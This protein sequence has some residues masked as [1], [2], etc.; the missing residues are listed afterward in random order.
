MPTIRIPN[1][2]DPR[3]Y[4]LGPWK[5]LEAG[6][7]RAFLLWHRRAGKDDFC[8][9][10]T[11]RSALLRPATYW[12]MLPQAA[13]ARKAIWEAVNPHTGIRRIDEAFPHAIR[14]TTREQEMMIRFKN[15]ST[16]QVVGSDNFNSLV[17]SPPA[18][19]V[20]SEFALAD[21]SA[22]AYLRP[23]LAENGGWALFVTT[24]R[25]KNHAYKL[26]KHAEDSDDWFCQRLT[27]DDTG[28][29]TPET[30]ASEL[31][32]MI[33]QFGPEMGRSLFDQEYY[34]SFDA[35]NIGAVYG[36]QMA[37]MEKDGRIRA[38]LYDPE[39]PVNTAWDL[40][41]SDATV[42]WFW[43]QAGKEVRLIDHYKINMAEPIQ[44]FEAMMG[45][46]YVVEERDLET[47][48]VIKGHWGDPLTDD[49]PKRQADFLHRTQYKWGKHY[50]PHDAGYKLLAAGG[51]SFVDQ[52]REVGITLLVVPQTSEINSVA[53]ARKTL[54]HTWIDKRLDDGIEALKQYHYAWDEK[55][56][57][58]SPSP[59]HDWSSHD[60]DA[61]EIIGQVWQAPRE[62]EVK[63]APRFLHEMTANEAFWPKSSSQSGKRR[64]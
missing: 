32:E 48:K 41:R 43:Q 12:H 62:S 27:A 64:I 17:G 11:A 57:I 19:V 47:G 24:P 58:F 42:I 15:G 30:L 31:A 22:W 34:C 45:R 2:W 38:D 5:A 55:N 26:F 56:K 52:G 10:W 37:K 49:D 14:E 13:Q 8:L 46:H 39:L 23:I 7:K 33:E 60:A 21:P 16:W 9:H 44:L 28:V 35:A 59:V 51:R 63:P 1:N 18:G 40:G 61:V 20:F 29:F 50:V 4:Q 54:G 6:I 3:H 53:A 36:S 25:G